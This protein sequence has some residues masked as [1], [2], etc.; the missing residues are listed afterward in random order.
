M[1]ITIKQA[2]IKNSLFLAYKYDQYVKNAKKS[3]S[4]S[5]DAPIHDD[6]RNAFS[7]LIPHFAFICEEIKESDC[8]DRINNP[9]DELPEEH[10]LL[11]YKTHGFTISGQGDS[12]GVTIS[13]TK[14][15]ESGKVLSLNTPFLKFEDYNDYS[16]MGE[17]REAIDNLKSEVYE[18]LEGKQAPPKQQA[19][20]LDEEEVAM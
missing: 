1:N 8:Q 5:S 18:Y 17:L 10:I 13:G 7:A 3:A 9:D 6:L 16:F 20:D 11:K 12:E 15:L 14:R 2:N 19:M 4:E